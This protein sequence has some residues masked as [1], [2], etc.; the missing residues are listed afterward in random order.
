MPALCALT[1]LLSGAETSSASASGLI[2]AAPKTHRLFMGV[3][4]AIERENAFHRVRDVSGGAFLITVKGEPVFVPTNLKSL[5][6]KIDQSLKLTTKSATISHLKGERAYTPANDPNRRFL[7]SA[8]SASAADAATSLAAGRVVQ[9]EFAVSAASASPEGSSV[10]QRQA[11]QDAYRDLGQSVF[12]SGTDLNSTGF[13]AQKLQEELALEL[14]DA[15]EVS[16]EL[17]S[18]VPLNNPYMLVVTQFREPDAREGMVR[19]W[20]YAKSLDPITEK[21]RKVHVLQGGFPPG[22]TLVDYRVH[23]YNQGEEVATNVSS[24]RVELTR[25]EA[26]QYVLIDYVTA[27]KGATLPATPAMGELPPDLQSRLAGGQFND[28]FFVKVSKDGHAQGTF[29]DKECARPVIDDYLESV[30]RGIRFKPALEKGSPVDGVA[31]VVLA[32]LKI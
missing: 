30:M 26:F 7:A 11:L 12:S 13:Y 24:K 2:G 16:F 8:S 32:K 10:E 27:N 14:F 28:T 15:M 17:S 5:N 4:I 20:I 1:G 29:L 19:N 21:P 31:R 22:F 23:L 6:L 25:E 3:D 18:P 9:V